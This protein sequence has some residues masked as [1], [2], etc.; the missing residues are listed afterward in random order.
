MGSTSLLRQGI[1]LKI[2]SALGKGQ[3][4]NPAASTYTKVQKEYGDGNYL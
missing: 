4:D 2:A 1:W 3:P